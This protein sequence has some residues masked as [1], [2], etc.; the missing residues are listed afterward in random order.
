[1]DPTLSFSLERCWLSVSSLSVDMVIRGR[2]RGNDNG[3][4]LV[5]RKMIVYIA[6]S[7]ADARMEDQGLCLEVEL[8][9][10]SFAD[11]AC[12]KYR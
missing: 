7:C 8:I 12:P 4:F 3:A 9:R 6:W 1:M 5:W 11:I 10:V 2:E